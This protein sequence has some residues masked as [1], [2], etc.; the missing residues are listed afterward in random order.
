MSGSALPFLWRYWRTCW[1]L[2]PPPMPMALPSARRSG[3]SGAAPPAVA[4]CLVAAVDS[5]PMGDGKAC[6]ERVSAR[7]GMGH[8]L[9]AVAC[10][11]L[12]TNSA[13]AV[14]GVQGFFKGHV[15]HSRTVMTVLLLPPPVQLQVSELAR[16][17]CTMTRR[18]AVM[19]RAELVR[20][21]SL[22]RTTLGNPRGRH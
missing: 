21:T 18:D 17:T 11:W 5:R 10:R 3:A 1:V 19:R 9:A 20:R 14:R 2:G 7:H 22:A 13:R 8:G 6:Q 4:A 16:V 15:G 12:R